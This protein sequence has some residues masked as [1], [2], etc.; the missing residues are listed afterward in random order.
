[1]STTDVTRIMIASDSNDG[2]ETALAKAARLLDGQEAG[3]IR[4]VRTSYDRIAEE[5]AEVMPRTEQQALIDALMRADREA[6]QQLIDRQQPH[7]HD[8][9]ME[10]LWRKQAADAI[11]EAAAKWPAQL[12]IK[13]ASRHH[14][15]TDFLHTPLDWALSRQAPCPVLISRNGWNTGVQRILAAV[16]T[17]DP[18]HASLNGEILRQACRV[19]RILGAEVHVASAYPDLGQAVNELQVAQDFAGIKTNMRENR[20]RALST[21]LQEL[22]LTVHQI[23]LLEGK[24]VHVIPTLAR[25]LDAPLSVF[26]T[27]ARSGVS[28]LL[29]GNTA[30]ALM[31]RMA[32]DLLTVRAPWS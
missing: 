4:V 11:V 24:A 15:L 12:L 21:L 13:P 5:P 29:L 20:Q 32:G 30:E 27:A 7:G 26:G 16:D 19:G 31:A 9:D 6:L 23:H 10:L 1:M 2:M 28:R 14:G 18:D 17:G 22:E 8:V 25:E 3:Q